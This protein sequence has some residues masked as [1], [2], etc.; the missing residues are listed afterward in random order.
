MVIVSKVLRQHY[1]GKLPLNT[2]KLNAQLNAML[3]ALRLP[4]GRWD[5][6][7]LLT[8]DKHIN[9]LNK[10]HR[11]KDKSTDILSF[12]NYKVEVP[13]VLPAVRSESARYLGDM[14]LSVPYI[15]A[16]CR[17]NETTL[18]ERM[19]ILVGH[20]LCHLMGYDHETDEDFATMSE[21]ED[22]LL[23]DYVR[24]LPSQYRRTKSRSNNN[25]I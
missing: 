6:G 15:E 5:A 23:A 8:T 25:D 24:H 20:G 3:L 17:D 16:Y 19:P 1:G 4:G 7:L 13:G 2:T 10:T 14:F 18:D 22:A 11:G 9:F 12:P 21:R